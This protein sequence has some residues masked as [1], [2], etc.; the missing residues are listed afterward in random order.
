M[1]S[2]NGLFFRNRVKEYVSH[3]DTNAIQ[4]LKSI[5]FSHLQKAGK[6]PLPSFV[7]EQTAQLATL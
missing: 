2:K 1:N 6:D 3:T 7:L 5:L 4:Q